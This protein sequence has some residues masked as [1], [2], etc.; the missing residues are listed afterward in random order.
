M[1]VSVGDENELVLLDIN[2]LL[3]EAKAKQKAY[4]MGKVQFSGSEAVPLEK[5]LI[6]AKTCEVDIILINLLLVLVCFCLI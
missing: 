4:L 1:V 5:H 3:G 6:K 2:T